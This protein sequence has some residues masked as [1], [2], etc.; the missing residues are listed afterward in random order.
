MLGFRDCECIGIPHHCFHYHN[1]V[2]G[3]K[4]MLTTLTTKFE[5]F[6]GD[7]GQ[8]DLNSICFSVIIHTLG[9]HKLVL[10]VFIARFHVV[11]HH[12]CDQ[13]AAPKKKGSSPL[14]CSKCRYLKGGCS[15]CK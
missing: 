2:V 4:K 6:H 14:G 13:A 12:R 15:A 10:S 11:V 3:W 7:D 1:H 8:N 9:L 5:D